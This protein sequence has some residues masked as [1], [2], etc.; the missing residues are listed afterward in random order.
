MN[1]AI[2]GAAIPETIVMTS[3]RHQM[4]GIGGIAGQLATA[5]AV[6]ENSVLLH[7][8]LGADNNGAHIRKL[9]RSQRIRHT[10]NRNPGGW[11]RITLHP[12]GEVARAQ[13]SWPPT[14]PCTKEFTRDIRDADFLILAT[15]REVGVI[16]QYLAQANQAKTPVMLV[17]TTTGTA[18]T[19]LETAQHPKEIVSMNIAEFQRI[20]QRSGMS[21]ADDVR[22]AINAR[23]M[24]VTT[25]AQGWNLYRADTSGLRSAAPAAPQASSFVG[26]GDY[27]AAGLCHAIAGERNDAGI[28][29][30]VNAHILRKIQ[31][32]HHQ[33]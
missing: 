9:L 11:A 25:G 22:R 33:R 7:A 1:Y 31:Q 20:S 32:W 16:R 3:S 21:A 12:D 28:I 8:A 23:N 30:S 15:Y 5:L 6:P 13:G 18:A 17:V 27:A 2:V 10:D 24:L 19:L 4:E 26:C 29:E 14:P